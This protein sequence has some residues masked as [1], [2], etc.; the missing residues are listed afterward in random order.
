MY[1]FENDFTGCEQHSS[2]DGGGGG[3]FG[4]GNDRK[5]INQIKANNRR[6]IKERETGW[7][8]WKKK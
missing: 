1:Y 5:N 4:V 3:G 2:C 7:N 6:K 8:E